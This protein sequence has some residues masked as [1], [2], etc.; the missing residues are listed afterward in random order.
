[1]EENELW[2]GHLI[3]LTYELII[4]VYVLF[5]SLPSNL[6]L[7]PP[8]LIFFVAIIKYAQWSY[9][10]YKSSTDG[11][12]RSDENEKDE[13]NALKGAFDMYSVCKP[14][15]VDVI[16]LVDVY[17]VIGDMLKEMTVKDVLGLTSKELSYAYDE[18]YTKDIVNCSRVNVILRVI[19]SSCI[20]LAF[21]L[22]IFSPMHGF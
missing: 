12:H 21:L 19:C 7:T 18:M 2:A 20:L 22:F 14:F 8:L 5:Q 4:V 17:K 9:L 16:P 3:A 15:F 10:L 13:L 6:L 1:M 11:F